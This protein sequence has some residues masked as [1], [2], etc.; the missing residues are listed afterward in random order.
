MPQVHF[1]SQ[2]FQ[3]VGHV[4]PGFCKVSPTMGL[5]IYAAIF[6]NVFY[7]KSDFSVKENCLMHSLP[8][9]LM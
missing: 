9:V 5:P 1:A 7:N 2:A 4:F 3:K 6:Y 8:S